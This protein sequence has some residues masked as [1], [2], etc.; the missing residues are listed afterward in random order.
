MEHF[1]I[2]CTQQSQ[3]FV[4]KILQNLIKYKIHSDSSIL[5]VASL[6]WLTLRALFSCP[7][8]H[9]QCY[10]RCPRVF[11]SGVSCCCRTGSV[12]ASSLS[13]LHRADRY[14][15]SLKA[16]WADSSPSMLFELMCPVTQGVPQ[17]LSGP[18]S[19]KTSCLWRRLSQSRCPPPTL[20][21]NLV[22]G[23]WVIVV[24]TCVSFCFPVF[25]GDFPKGQ[26][27]SDV[28]HLPFFFFF[29]FF[30]TSQ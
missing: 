28:I 24:A 12:Y 1:V 26:T 2:T 13:C 15:E 5:A 10:L 8:V 19:H 25:E 6:H 11:V 18:E 30:Q 3:G 21:R 16:S 14:L 23:L 7:Y 4:C 29:F 20:Y 22:L 27:Y 17:I 9:F